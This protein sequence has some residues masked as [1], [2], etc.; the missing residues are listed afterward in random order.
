MPHSDVRPPYGLLVAGIFSLF[1]AVGGTCSGAAWA[2]FDSVI[3]R[4]KE[5]KRFWRLV[6]IY[7]LGAV[8]FI[9]HFLYRLYGF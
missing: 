8:W 7:Y 4:A 3:Y 1:L 5:P 9:G 2:R 6:A